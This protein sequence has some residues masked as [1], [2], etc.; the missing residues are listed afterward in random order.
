MAA[1]RVAWRA[2]TERWELTDRPADLSDRRD[3]VV[4]A[5][6]PQP[7]STS[8]AD[9]AATTGARWLTRNLARATERASTLRAVILGGVI[10]LSAGRVRDRPPSRAATDYCRSLRRST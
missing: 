5:P 4:V 9:A 7:V 3:V 8:A 10:S 2:G 6:L 1:A